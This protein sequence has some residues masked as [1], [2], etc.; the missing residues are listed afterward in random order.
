MT[1]K[2][3]FEQLS[4][5]VKKGMKNPFFVMRNLSE[6]FGEI[7]DNVVDAG[8][9]KVTVTQTLTEGTEIGSIKV[10]NNTTVLYAP[11]AS[12]GGGYNYS[13]NE[14]NTGRKWIDGRDI[15]SKCFNNVT[16]KQTQD[17]QLS[18]PYSNVIAV[19]CFGPA[20]ASGF[21][22]IPVVRATMADTIGVKTDVYPLSITADTFTG[23]VVEA[24]YCKIS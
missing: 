16:V 22:S 17:A 4:A 24:L 15:Y 21:Q 10:N 9:D 2:E 5:T 1:I 19:N 13:T 12:A 6:K 20:I 8:G 18:V 7:A 23:C 11:N 3:A 14:V